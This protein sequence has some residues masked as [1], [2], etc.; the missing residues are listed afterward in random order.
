M[1]LNQA[2]QKKVMMQSPAK[3]IGKEAAMLLRNS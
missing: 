1:R 2:T 3:G